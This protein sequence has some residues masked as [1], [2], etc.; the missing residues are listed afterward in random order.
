MNNR[1]SPMT[2]PFV[3]KECLHDSKS[4]KLRK[5][6]AE[7]RERSTT[8]L[9]V[10]FRQ[11]S[12]SDLLENAQVTVQSAKRKLMMAMANSDRAELNRSASNPVYGNLKSDIN[13]FMH[14]LDRNLRHLQNAQNFATQQTLTA[15]TRAAFLR[16]VQIVRQKQEAENNRKKVIVL[17]HK[18]T[19]EESKGHQRDNTK[20]SVRDF[21]QVLAE[22]QDSDSEE[23][24]D[25]FF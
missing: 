13:T 4:E 2:S 24:V 16:A 19:F 12:N 1:L 3:V 5:A 10:A 7:A 22:A 6:L 9:G 18:S 23:E 11:K 8:A 21:L 14:L 17:N 15:V 20:I 25:D